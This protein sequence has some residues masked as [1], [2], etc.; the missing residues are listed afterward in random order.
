MDE[1]I[2]YTAI[3]AAYEAGKVLIEHFGK[4]DRVGKK[5]PIDLVTDADYASES[6]IC[7]IIS[8]RFPGHSIL[9]EESGAS[10]ND[11]SSFLWVVDPLDGTTN[12]AHGLPIF[13]VSIALMHK[14]E[15]ILGVVLNPVCGEL[16]MASRGKGASLNGKPISVSTRKRLIDSLLVTGFPYNVADD[17]GHYITKFERCL[18]SAR[19]L[20]RLGSAALDLC[21]VACGRF[22]GFWEENL[23]PWDTAAGSIIVNEA[24]GSVTDF[25]G[26]PF[27]I[28][29]KE[30]LATNGKIHEEIR[31]RLGYA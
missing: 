30:I 9:A 25:S 29:K 28:H 18:T 2:R 5:G 19:G 15:V 24:G 14:D 31:S 11:G 8:A 6:V 23:K 10:S 26:A 20:R 12:F 17:S 3:R 27:N 4:L 22:D 21:F 7:D 1:A 13:A 16:F